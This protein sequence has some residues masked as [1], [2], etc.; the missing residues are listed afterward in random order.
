MCHSLYY[1]VPQPSSKTP[2]K[3]S[4][5]KNNDNLAYLP[6]YTRICNKYCSSSA[7]YDTLKNLSW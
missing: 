3:K 1:A 4:A 5:K 2:I 6:G 7:P